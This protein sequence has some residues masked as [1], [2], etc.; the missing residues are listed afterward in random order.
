MYLA[1]HQK[2]PDLLHHSVTSGIEGDDICA[3]TSL[4]E[5]TGIL[6]MKTTQMNSTFRENDHQCT[7]GLIFFSFA[8]IAQLGVVAERESL[9]VIP[10]NSFLEN[11]FLNFVSRA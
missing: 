4:P 10:E 9:H 5:P 11:S 8:Y 2:S 6:E 1:S 3:L 7:S